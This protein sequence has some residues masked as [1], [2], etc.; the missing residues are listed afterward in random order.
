MGEK[1]NLEFAKQ[2]PGGSR[3]AVLDR[4]PQLSSSTLF[5]F[6]FGFCFFV[7]FFLTYSWILNITRY[8]NFIL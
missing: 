3:L 1:N 4:R 8:K 5:G 6:L 7:V 2:P